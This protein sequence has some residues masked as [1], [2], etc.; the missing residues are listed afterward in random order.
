MVTAIKVSVVVLV[1]V[2]G[3]QL[4]HQGRQLLADS[5]PSESPSTTAA[6]SINPIFSLL[7][8]PKE[9]LRMVRRAGQIVVFNFAFIE[10]DI[11]WHHGR[12]TQASSAR[13]VPQRFS[14][15]AGVAASLRH[16]IGELLSG[17]GSYATR[18]RTGPRAGKSATAFPTSR[19][20]WASG[21]I[22]VGAVEGAYHGGDGVDARAMPRVLSAM[23]RDGGARGR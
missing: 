23:A 16:G 5:F 21:I 14:R 11:T 1:V 10:F 19:V 12:E 7:T 20:Y 3:C 6:G 13:R 2:V 22:S 4:L 17:H 15:V 18:M 8:G 9:P